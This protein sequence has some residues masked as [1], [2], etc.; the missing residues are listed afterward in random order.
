MNTPSMGFTEPQAP[1][2]SFH[3]LNHP[4]LHTPS[5]VT[6]A[7]LH[8]SHPTIASLESH[9][10]PFP[11][12]IPASASPGHTP[13]HSIGIPHVAPFPQSTHIPMVHTPCPSFLP[14]YTPPCMSHT[15][16]SLM[17]HSTRTPTGMTSTYLPV[18][19]IHAGG[20]HIQLCLLHT[21]T[22]TPTTL[23]Y[24]WSLNVA[25]PGSTGPTQIHTPVLAFHLSPPVLHTHPFLHVIQH[26]HPACPHAWSR[27]QST[28]APFRDNPCSG[29]P[30]GGRFR[31]SRSTGLSLFLPLPQPGY[32]NPGEHPCPER[33]TSHTPQGHTGSRR[34]P[35]PSSL[36]PPDPTRTLTTP[37]P[38]PSPSHRRQ[39]SQP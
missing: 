15:P 3:T 36:T 16:L 20:S 26:T 19:H 23:S 30:Q 10:H 24:S 7:H 31:S 27:I 5:D 21:H 8:V 1:A 29:H 22:L 38:P 2:L 6:V 25:Y 35:R 37:L 12:H 11:C 4:Q 34:D 14:P 9:P 32:A 33:V 39:S 28:P 13:P 18:S 17:C